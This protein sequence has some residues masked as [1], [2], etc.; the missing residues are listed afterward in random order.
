MFITMFFYYEY[1]LYWKAIKISSLVDSFNIKSGTTV[2]CSVVSQNIITVMNSHL[3]G[4]VLSAGVK[5]TPTV[6]YMQKS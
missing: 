6:S 5:N 3:Y 1:L 2:S 4:L